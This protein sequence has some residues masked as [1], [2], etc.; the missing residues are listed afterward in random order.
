MRSRSFVRLTAAG[1]I[2]ESAHNSKAPPGP[3]WTEL[4]HDDPNALA[5]GRQ[6]GRRWWVNPATG[7]VEARKRIHIDS[8]GEVRSVGETVTL[9]FT[10]VPQSISELTVK[11]GSQSVKVPHGDDLLITWENSAQVT[12]ALDTFQLIAEPLILV[13]E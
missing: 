9:K 3:G 6:G 1:Q 2:T 11:I 7:L 4:S 12:V 5:A 8:D 13:W 10:G